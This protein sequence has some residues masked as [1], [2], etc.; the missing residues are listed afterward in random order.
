MKKLRQKFLILPA[1]LLSGSL[2][3]QCSSSPR[4][5]LFQDIEGRPYELDRWLPLSISQPQSIEIIR[6]SQIQQTLRQPSAAF[7]RLQGPCIKPHPPRDAENAL[8]NLSRRETS[9]S[10]PPMAVSKEIIKARYFDLDGDGAADPLVGLSGH[11]TG[12]LTCAYSLFV[13]RGDCG[14]AV[15]EFWAHSARI[16]LYSESHGLAD[17]ETTVID[18]QQIRQELHRFDGQSYKKVAERT[19]P[20]Q[21][22]ETYQPGQN[23]QAQYQWSTWRVELK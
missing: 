22:M 13:M 3:L 18:Q 17:L 7:P 11:C 4:R 21:G 2:L 20:L 9:A 1:L 23:T 14:H 6:S 8:P 10:T 16:R 12:S 19:A 15:G 5:S